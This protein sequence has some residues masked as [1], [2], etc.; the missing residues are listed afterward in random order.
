MNKIK[1]GDEVMV[2]CGRSKGGKGV[3][4]RVFLDAAGKPERVLVEGLNMVT[5]YDRANPQDSK[6]GGLIK[7]EA[8][9]HASNVTLLDAA[10]GRPYR[11]KIASGEKGRSR[12]SAT[13]KEVK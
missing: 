6:P 12:Q 8:S 9:I 2:L 5:H 7:R 3:V 11:V 4:Q 1:R 10:S 13:G